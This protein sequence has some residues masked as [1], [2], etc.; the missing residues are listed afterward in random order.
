MAKD[1]YLAS[2]VEPIV[3]RLEALYDEIQASPSDKN[4]RSVGLAIN[5]L[6]NVVD[7]ITEEEDDRFADMCHELA[8]EQDASDLFETYSDVCKRE[9]MG[10]FDDP[11]ES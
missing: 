11:E 5:W 8:A 1:P 3:K 2:V 6:M 10:Y 9:A 4:K 7:P